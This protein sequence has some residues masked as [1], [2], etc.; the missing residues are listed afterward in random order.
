MIQCWGGIFPRLIDGDLLSCLRRGGHA[1]ALRTDGTLECWGSNVFGQSDA[2]EGTFIDVAAGW[3]HSCAI[4]T[5]GAVECWG[6]NLYGVT[7]APSGTFAAIVAPREVSYMCGIRTSGAV[8]CW[9]ASGRGWRN[10]RGAFASL[11]LGAN[12]S[13]GVRTN[14]TIECWDNSGAGNNAGQLDMPD[15]AFI[16]I[17]AGGW[18]TCGL[19]ADGGH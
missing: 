2:P 3:L 12:H 5:G 19:R 15:T 18:H 8:E 10:I 16:A 1:C 4:R 9:G 11:T 14:G 13:C 6:D 7:E 17:S